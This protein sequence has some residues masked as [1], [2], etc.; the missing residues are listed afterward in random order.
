MKRTTQVAAVALGIAGILGCLWG[1]SFLYWQ[2]QVDEA[3]R[4]LV[5][6][7]GGTRISYIDHAEE[8]RVLRR[9]GCRAFPPLVRAL[10]DPAGG[11]LPWQLLHLLVLHRQT[12]DP[13]AENERCT[14]AIIALDRHRIR[15]GDPPDERAAKARALRDWWIAEGPRLHRGWRT[16]TSRCP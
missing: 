12:L 9:A 7:S 8:F 2:R 15:L 16:W 10:E 3:I 4:A 6:R 5:R 14:A 13:A 11:E 1:A